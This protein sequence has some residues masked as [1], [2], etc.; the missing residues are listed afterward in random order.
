[1]YSDNKFIGLGGSRIKGRFALSISDG[2]F[3]GSSMPSQSYGN[4]VL[5]KTS[6]F[7][8]NMIEVWALE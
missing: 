6:D 2:F 3:K 8:I 4:E 5:S 1:M 7:K